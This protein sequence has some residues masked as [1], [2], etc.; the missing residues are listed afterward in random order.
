MNLLFLFRVWFLFVFFV[1]RGIF[2]RREDAWMGAGHEQGKAGQG[3]SKSV[4]V[5]LEYTPFFVWDFFC[6]LFFLP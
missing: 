2:R 5:S 3:M 4:V 1:F 6:C